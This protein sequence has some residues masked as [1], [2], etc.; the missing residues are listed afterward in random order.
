[1]KAL[2]LKHYLTM[3]AAALFGTASF[4]QDAIIPTFGQIGVEAATACCAKAQPASR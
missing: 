3:S 4:A 2:S 1:M